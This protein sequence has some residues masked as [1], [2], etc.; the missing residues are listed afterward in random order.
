MAVT[1]IADIV[2]PE[3]IFRDYMVERTAQKSRIFQSGMVNRDPEIST[4]ASGKGSI[5]ELPFWNDVTGSSEILDDSNALTPASMST[6]K[7]RA[8][9]HYRGAAWQANDLAAALAGDDPLESVLNQVGQ[10]WARDMQ[11]QILVP[12]LTGIFDGPLSSTH[13]KDVAIEDGNNAG[14]SEKISTQNILDTVALLGDSWDQITAMVVHSVV[15]FKMVSLNLINFEPLSEQ[16][17]TIPRFLG[18]EVIVDDSVY[19]EAG[20]TSGTKYSTYM[21]G[22]GAVA[23]GEG[24]APSL[25]DEEAVETDRD[26]LAGNDI[27]ITRRHMIFHP[28]GLKFTGTPSG[29]SPSKSEL[30][31]GSNWAKAF[32]D[33]NIPILELVTN[34]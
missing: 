23:F 30:E 33:K 13:V 5:F 20:N 12:S 26:S 29:T 14:D 9:K 15:Y 21:F 1:K 34:G 6:E 4:F 10:Y 2:K 8:I 31:D 27:F 28:R 7:E 32:E 25:S 11:R 19:T 3:P 16:G 22:Q 24:S 17:I 18:R